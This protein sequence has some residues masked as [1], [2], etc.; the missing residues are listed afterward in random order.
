[1]QDLRGDALRQVFR[2]GCPGSRVELAPEMQ[3]SLWYGKLRA[4]PEVELFV[5]V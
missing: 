4:V 5:A 1:M 2:A 3:E